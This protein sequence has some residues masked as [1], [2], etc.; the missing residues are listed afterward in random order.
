MTTIFGSYNQDTSLS[1]AASKQAD[2]ADFHADTF[3]PSF[4]LGTGWGW[5][6]RSEV[7]VTS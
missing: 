6:V 5:P 7:S 2:Y 1:S 4:P 3:L